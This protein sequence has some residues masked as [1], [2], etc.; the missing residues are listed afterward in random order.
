MQ[1]LSKE[2]VERKK[3]TLLDKIRKGALFIYPT[4]TIYGIGCSA[5]NEKSVK[6]VREIKERPDKPFSVIIPSKEW[7][8]TNCETTE[9]VMKWVMKLPG[10]YTLI[11]KLKNKQAIAKPVNTGIATIGIRIPDHWISDFVKELGVPIITPSANISGKEVM[12]SEEDMDPAFRAKVDYMFDEGEK[13][14]QPS[15][16]VDLSS[17]REI[18]IR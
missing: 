2:E 6:K 14:G 4:D 5:L 15:Q 8:S 10:P 18:R 3:E 16:I 7:I 9:Q 11:L 12:T 17:G 13:K 1:V